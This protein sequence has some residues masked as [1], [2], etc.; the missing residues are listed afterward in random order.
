M[1]RNIASISDYE[2]NLDK[3]LPPSWIPGDLADI[4]EKARQYG[5]EPVLLLLNKLN[6]PSEEQEAIELWL[7]VILK[8]EASGSGAPAAASTA[9][10]TSDRANRA[11]DNPNQTPQRS[12]GRINSLTSPTGSSTVAT[13]PSSFTPFQGQGHSL[14]SGSAHAPSN[15]SRSQLDSSAA[16]HSPAASSKYSTPGADM[17]LLL[18]DHTHNAA[19]FSSF[20]FESW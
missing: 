4:T 11:A 15:S 12:S 2:I 20:D 3:A 7:Q 16:P 9:S 14:A 5:A 17:I 19:L 8:P 18:L 10:G 1:A 6:W 13:K